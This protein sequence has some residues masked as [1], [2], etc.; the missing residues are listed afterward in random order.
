MTDKETTAGQKDAM[1]A[2]RERFVARW[3]QLIV[4]SAGNSCKGG[5][6]SYPGA[7]D[8]YEKALGLKPAEAWLI[9]RLLSFDWDGKKYVWCS[10]RKISQEADVSYNQVL[11]LAK[12]LEG[13]GYLRDMGQHRSDS[14]SQVRDWSIA[15]LLAAMEYAILC[16][17]T[18]EAGEKKA[19]SLGHPVTMADLW[20]Y[21]S[22]PKTG[23]PFDP[24]LPFTTPR[25]LN[26][27]MRKQGK[28]P[29]WD[30]HYHGSVDIPQPQKRE[31]VPHICECGK[32]FLSGS[33]NPA[34]RCPDCRKEIKR[35]SMKTL[36]NG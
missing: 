5:A 29:G 9:K 18:T 16:D 36:S 8:R 32:T 11:A 17:P 24:Y 25:Q 1:N 30:P 4:E 22:G 34:T 14:F 33:R 7:L 20:L 3:G 10:L 31:P 27:Y 23:Q 35:H 21:S 28:I 19:Q 26:E 13:K 15:G 6:Y 12:A 2:N